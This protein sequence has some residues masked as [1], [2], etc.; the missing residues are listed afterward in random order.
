MTQGLEEVVAATTRLSHVDGEAGRLTLCGYAAEDLAP[1]ATFEDVA[2][3]FLE[4]RLPTP[5]E[6]LGFAHDLAARRAVPRAVVDVLREA[7]AL[8]TSPM[9]ALLMAVPLLRL[10][11]PLP[12]ATPGWPPDPAPV[13]LHRPDGASFR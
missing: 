7:A 1:H 8:D 9:D 12:R 4:G 5:S 2:F 13:R 10:G 11:R 6:R 3:L